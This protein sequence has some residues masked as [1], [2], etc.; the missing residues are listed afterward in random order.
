MSDKFID[1][2]TDAMLWIAIV[3]VVLGL[4]FLGL[5]FN[6]YSIESTCHIHISWM[7]AIFWAGKTARCFVG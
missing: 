2:V 3:I 7:K 5:W 4:T 1:A 6:K